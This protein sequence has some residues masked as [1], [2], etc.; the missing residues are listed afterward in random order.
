MLFDKKLGY[1]KECGE[2]IKKSYSLKEYGCKNA[3]ECP[4]CKYPN[5]KEDLWGYLP[6]YLIKYRKKNGLGI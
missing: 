3:Y 6:E 1:C 5:G 2:V 4:H